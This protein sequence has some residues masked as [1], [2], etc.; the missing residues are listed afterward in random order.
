MQS[1]SF[2]H[3]FW[4]RVTIHG[5]GACLRSETQHQSVGGAGVPRVRNVISAIPLFQNQCLFAVAVYLSLLNESGCVLVCSGGMAHMLCSNGAGASSRPL[6]SP[7]SSTRPPS[8]VHSVTVQK[9]SAQ[10]RERQHHSDHTLGCVL[11]TLVTNPRRTDQLVECRIGTLGHAG[12][13]RCP[14]REMLAS[15]GD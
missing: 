3:Q 10:V 15:A 9:T 13:M 11:A 8:A 5:C 2:A 6:Q 14:S 7:S 1:Q 4:A 12:L